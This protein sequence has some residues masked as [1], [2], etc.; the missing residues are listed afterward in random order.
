MLTD[1]HLY[2]LTPKNSIMLKELEFMLDK[3][4]DI[5][6]SELPHIVLRFNRK[7]K[8]NYENPIEKQLIKYQFEGWE[9]L[10]S[11]FPGLKMVPHYDAFSTQKINEWVRKAIATDETYKPGNFFNY[12]RIEFGDAK[13]L[14]EIKEEVD[15]WKN[16]VEN[17]YL[18]VPAPLPFVDAANDPRAVN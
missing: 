4:E 11:K 3:H 1:D 14:V 15:S 16:I 7:L 5:V 18:Y 13:K 6:K 12:F 2:L 8:L 17:S 9:K 10:K